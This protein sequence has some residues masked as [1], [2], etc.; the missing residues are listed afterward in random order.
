MPLNIKIKH[1]K[2]VIV[3]FYI[4][5]IP[6]IIMNIDVVGDFFNG[7]FYDLL[8]RKFDFDDSWIGFYIFYSWFIAIYY[9][10]PLI[11]FDRN[12]FRP[13]QQAINVL[14]W[15]YIKKSFSAVL[16]FV[17]FPFISIVGV[18]VWFVIS[19]VGWFLGSI[20]GL[21]LFIILVVILLCVPIFLVIKLIKIIKKNIIK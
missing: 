15:E 13:D 4:I 9:F 11:V 6:T 21:I 12:R 10:Y 2:I 8:M 7:E 20:G 14:S 17:F 19:H 1:L 5:T 18:L 3:V 16:L